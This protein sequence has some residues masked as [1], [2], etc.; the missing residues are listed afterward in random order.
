[1][2]K[3]NKYTSNILVI[4]EAK[5]PCFKDDRPCMAQRFIGSSVHPGAEYITMNITRA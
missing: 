2:Y 3:Y 4:L 1:M 5:V